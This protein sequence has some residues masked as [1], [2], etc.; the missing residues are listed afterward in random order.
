[1]AVHFQKIYAEISDSYETVNHVLTFGLD[2]RWRRTCVS[3]ALDGGGSRIL[4]VCTGTGETAVYLKRFGGP[5]V[6]V[7]AADFSPDMLAIA[8]SKPEATGIL[9]ALAEA[10]SLPY[11]DGT[12]DAVTIT[13]A[14][15]NI[16]TSREALVRRFAEFR[17]V[18]RPGGRF[19]NLETSR[20]SS[21]ILRRLM[22]MYVGAAVRPAG[23]LLSGTDAGYA[24]LSHSI[25][26]FYNADELAA[27]LKDA[28]FA[29]VG[30]RSMMFGAVALHTA[31]K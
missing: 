10:D 16:N 30:Y 27:V 22:D 1:M 7:A 12:F 14:T 29:H 5:G 28:G 20:P 17:R 15:R 31:M 18:L 21:P 26:R 2:R 19:V 25:R 6:T 11:A 23:R 24:Y 9:F 13:F 3:E 4:D 8:R